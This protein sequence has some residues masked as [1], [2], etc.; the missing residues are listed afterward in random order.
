MLYP[1]NGHRATKKADKCNF[2]GYI[3]PVTRELI[4][5]MDARKLSAAQVAERLGVQAQTIRN[6]RACGVPARKEDHLRQVMAEWDAR[7]GAALGALLLRPTPEEFR[8]WN[9][10]AL[11]EGK[12]IEDWAIEGLN[13]L[14]EEEV[15]EEPR[16]R[17]AEDPPEF[18]V[19]KRSSQ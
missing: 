17:V 14:A 2:S 13:R 19:T 11:E 4:E 3:K 8:A 9:Q 5:W 15:E 6:W 10:A 16:L 7:P 18:R 12:L 1:E